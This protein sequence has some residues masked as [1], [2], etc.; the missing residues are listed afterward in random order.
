[1]KF[2]QTPDGAYEIKKLDD[3]GQ[4]Y[5]K[6]DF[7]DQHGTFVTWLVLSATTSTISGSGDHRNDGLCL[8][9]RGKSR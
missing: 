4:V 7:V 3:D 2:L 5:S 8:S 9:R 6:N 1:M